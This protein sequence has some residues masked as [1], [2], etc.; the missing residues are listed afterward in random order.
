MQYHCIYHHQT[1]LSSLLIHLAVTVGTASCWWPVHCTSKLITH[2]STRNASKEW[3]PVRF[4]ITSLEHLLGRGWWWWSIRFRWQHKR[5][6]LL[7]CAEFDVKVT[8]TDKETATCFRSSA[9]LATLN[10]YYRCQCC[11]I[12]RGEATLIGLENKFGSIMPTNWCLGM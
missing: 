10:C 1:S 5:I 8:F 4:L 2:A 6:L 12:A 11:Q 9:I 3:C 7:T